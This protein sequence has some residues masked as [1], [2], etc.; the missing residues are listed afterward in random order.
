MRKAD[1]AAVMTVAIAICQLTRQNPR[2][3]IWDGE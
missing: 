2:L 3:P 1:L